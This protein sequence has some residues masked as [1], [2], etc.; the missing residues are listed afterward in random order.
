MTSTRRK[1]KA[2]AAAAAAQQEA[3]SSQDT[4][5]ALTS[6]AFTVSLPS[7]IDLDALSALI[8]GEPLETPTED[9]VLHLYRTLLAHVT[10]LDATA[11]EVEEL[12]AEAEKKEV[13]LDQAYQDREN[14]KKEAANLADNLQK[15]LKSIKAER[16]ELATAKATLQAQLSSTSSSHNASSVE[17]DNLKTRVE[18]VEREKRD[19]VSIVSR[20]KG[21]CA[22]RDEEISTL[23]TSLKQSRHEYRELEGQTRELRSTENSSKYKLDSLSQ[24]LSLA[25]EE[26]ER[27][28]NELNR[29]SDDFSEYRRT[30]HTELLEAQ[31]ERDALAQ[32]SSTS[33][34]SIKALQ[35]ANKSLSQRLTQAL[36]RVQDLT[37]RLAEQEATYSSEAAG[38]RRLVVMMEEREQHAK[39]IVDGLERDWATVDEKAERRE[40]KLRDEIEREAKRADDAEQRVQELERLLRGLDTGDLPAAPS[41][42]NAS[43]VPRTPGSVPSTP[44]RGSVFVSPG[45]LGMMGLSP[46]VAMA[47]RA[48][49]SGKTFTEVY[50]EHVKL[51]E[52]YARKSAEYDHMDRTLQ[53]VLAQI[54]E[55][56]PIL[57]QQRLEYERLQVEAGQLASQLACALE[58]RDANATLA[59]ETSQKLKKTIRENELLESQLN[60]LGLQVRTL[61][62]ELARIQDPSIPSDE[63]LEA[64]P[65]MA[66]ATNMEEVITN[67]L[68][69]FRSIQGLQEQNQRL[70]KI[71]RDL[72]ARME[73]E[74]KGYRESLQQ[75]Q[76]EAVLEAHQALQKMQE[77]LENQKKRH[78]VTVQAY[79]KERDALRAM[80]ARAE[81]RA[82]GPTSRIYGESGVNGAS[83]SELVKELAEVQSQFET[84]KSEMGTDTIKLRD[85]VMLAQKEAAQLGAA[86]AKANASI[87]YLTDRH[88]MAQEQVAVSTR[89]I[90]SLNKHKQQLHEKFT[91]TDIECHRFTEDLLTASAK[92]DQLRNESA[93]LRAEKKIW[94]GV[95]LR[96]EEENRTLAV[97]RSHLSDLMANV[98]KMHND[99]ERS[100]E[101]DRR[102]LESQIQMLEGQT[103]DLRS[104]LSQERDSVRHIS[105]QKEIEVKDL[106]TRLEKSVEELGKTREALVGAET[107]RKHLEDRVQELTRRLQGNEEKL[108]VYERR[109]TTGSSTGPRSTDESLTREQQL[110]AEVAELRA[111]LKVA[112]VDLANARS[113]VLQ[114]QEISNANEEALISLNA[115][116]DEFKASTES[117]I[118]T[119]ESE[120][121]SLHEKLEA[122]QTELRESSK[123]LA[124]V[125]QNLENERK[126]WAEDKKLLEDTIADMSSTERSIENAR[127]SQQGEIQQLEERA[128]S[129][130][131]KY[132]REVVAHA[133]SIKAVEELR[134]QLAETRLTVRDA[135]TAAETAQVKLSTSE[136]SW[137]RQKEALEREVNELNVRRKDLVAQNTLLHNHLESVSTQ[138][139]KIRDAANSSSTT[140]GEG[141]SS[142]SKL[143]EL[144]SVVGWLRKEKEIVE[145]QLE[146][147]KQETAR[148][149]TQVDHL[150]QSLDQA[151]TSLSEERE[152]AAEAATT[153][154]DHDIL[155][156]KINELSVYRE[157]N[158]TLRAEGEAKGRRVVELDAKLR[159][160]VD[161]LTPAKQELLV[162]RAELDARDSQ[163]TRLTEDS[164]KWQERNQ[165]LLT[166][167]ERIDPDELQALKNENERLKAVEVALK[168]RP[169]VTDNTEVVD[170]LKKQVESSENRTKELT[171]RVRQQV[172]GLN[173]AIT[174]LR[175]QVTV[176]TAERDALKTQALSTVPQDSPDLKVLQD[177][178]MALQQEKSSVEASLDEVRA[179][180]TELSNQ[181][182][183]LA[184]VQKERDALLAEKEAWTKS[185]V[186]STTEG[187]SSGSWEEEK[188]EV[189]RERDE[190]LANCKK[191]QEQENQLRNQL[192]QNYMQISGYRKQV[193]ELEAEKKNFATKQQA[194]IDTALAAAKT[195]NPPATGF[196]NEEVEKKHAEG[197]KALEERLR[198]EHK[199]EL[200][201]AAMKVVPGETTEKSKETNVEAAIAAAKAEWETAHEEEI[202]KA[203]ERGR[204]EQQ[205]KGRLKDAQLMRTQ[206]KVK[207]LEAKVLE[208][209]GSSAASTSNSTTTVPA[210]KPAPTLPPTQKPAPTQIPGQKSTPAVNKPQQAAAQ[211]RLPNRPTPPIRGGGPGRALNVLGGRGG[212]QTTAAST[213][214]STGGVSI[215]GAAKRPR[216]D[217]EGETQT[218]DNS[219]V[220]RLKPAESKPTPPI[221]RPPPKQ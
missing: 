92:L 144:R 78:E 211:N 207:E 26:S 193:Q 137:E 19:L 33:E 98:Q 32:A 9:T 217:G 34:S 28:I 81:A 87:E 161:E 176:L 63:E 43:G 204:V 7:D 121:T 46:T 113:H 184:S 96:L 218:A 212:G 201:A 167:Y 3:A 91:R 203:I 44:V 216:E 86:L 22:Q 149:K 18:D 31:A 164:R 73:A 27:A 191:A 25:K 54:E 123:A 39:E 107:S 180:A 185:T 68:V 215:M 56:A 143:T 135:T 197:L 221:K 134:Q 47:S 36:T 115:T 194:A 209:Q 168:E 40:M 198:A 131:E 214:Q 187:A 95:Q 170:Q 150:S 41:I 94:E 110:E 189:L 162:L 138:A 79:Q 208:L 50:A 199:R 147:S 124:T 202:K 153:Q 169:P 20:L 140:P 219:L 119:Y 106:Q 158:A 220:K 100:G 16:D 114:F 122:A 35:A 148:L 129:A 192:K 29:K 14:D 64:D 127:A 53:A 195:E 183:T 71:V 125:Q 145:L 55:R 156:G 45:D 61:T 17:L 171:Q 142:D 49:R 51:Q 88:R 130:E 48:Q 104:Q 72:G 155:M 1:T 179:K 188:S 12:R 175:N 74:E 133:E 11:R 8:P 128:K 77:D 15:E 42:S 126:A 89:E 177:R 69:R 97:E 6:T 160:A 118:A 105:L 173:K 136:V 210:Q 21:D 157:S 59:Q 163:V 200:E 70:L 75:E 102:R 57:T 82:T 66:P 213:P 101:N 76:A 132:G 111:A 146:L 141:E 38:L 154:A 151:R 13:E 196:T 93:N 80:L 83:D 103:Q 2:A 178:I 10:Q 67:N 30:K 117:Q 90:E 109:S 52:E 60:D 99:L 165:Q 5:S 139:A 120:Q 206:A 181:T 58:D 166:K 172:T 85:D 159:Q 62:K 108:A 65:S 190:A 186:P 152:R 4:P 84:Y 205:T 182:A 116:Y 112:E 37:G 174:E 24:Q 23:R